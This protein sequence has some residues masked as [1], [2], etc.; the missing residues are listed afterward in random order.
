MLMA[1]DFKEYS[2]DFNFE[3]IVIVT[4]IHNCHLNWYNTP[5]EDRMELLCSSMKEECEKRPFDAILSLGDFS[6][7]FWKYNVGGSYLWDPPISRTAEFVTEYRA[8][9]PTEF[10]MIPG[11]HEQY[12]NETWEKITGYPREYSV[13]WGDTVFVMLD[14]FGGNL[15]PKEN[16]DGAYTGINVDFVKSVLERHSEKRIVLCAHDIIPKYESDEARNLI[17]SESRIACAFVGHTHKNN[18]QLLGADWRFFPLIYCGDFSYSDVRDK[19][20]NWG[21]RTLEFNENGMST[22]YVKK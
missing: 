17:A 3:R 16:H 7:D 10:F 13:V 5:T 18:V 20:K 14:T 11:N 19:E 22:L 12:G 4:D 9:M 21:Y 1:K 8:K 6:L 15:D 2:I